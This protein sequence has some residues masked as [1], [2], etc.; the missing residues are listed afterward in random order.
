MPTP[1]HLEQ[2]RRRHEKFW[3]NSEE[4]EGRP[5]GTRDVSQEEPRGWIDESDGKDE[6]EPTDEEKLFSFDHSAD[7]DETE[8]DSIGYDPQRNDIE[9]ALYGEQE[10][11]EFAKEMGMGIE[12]AERLIACHQAELDNYVPK[13]E[14]DD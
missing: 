2:I 4:P 13:K 7:E 11:L 9:E 8:D 3:A 5:V 6:A 1:E 14:D 10:G 12:E